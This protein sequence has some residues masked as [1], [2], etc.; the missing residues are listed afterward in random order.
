[1]T[2]KVFFSVTMTLDRFVAPIDGGAAESMKAGWSQDSAL[3]RW[4]TQWSELQEWVFGQRFF[5]ENLQLGEGGQTGSDN[6]FLQRTF[7]RTGS[8]VLGKRMFDAGEHSWPED[9]P[10]DTPVFVVTHQVREPWKRLG[11]TTFFRQRRYRERTPP[12]SRGG[13]GPGRAD[14]RRR[15]DHPP[16][17]QRRTGRRVHRLAPPGAV[18]H[19]HPTLRRDRPEPRRTG[20]GPHRAFGDGGPPDLHGAI[21]FWSQG[22]SASSPAATSALRV[23]ASRMRLQSRSKRARPYICRFSIFI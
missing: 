12:G 18:R 23:Y 8:T 19:G 21:A 20:P 1:M 15:R 6:E 7:E 17:P 16:V 5:R 14:R 4:M 11:G 9:P 2:G 3:R 10:F 22:L 13:R